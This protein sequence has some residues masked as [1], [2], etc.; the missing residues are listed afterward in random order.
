M[1]GHNYKLQQ[2]S[3][4]KISSNIF[5]RIKQLRRPKDVSQIANANGVSKILIFKA[6]QTGD[7]SEKVYE[8]LIVFYA[9]RALEESKNLKSLTPQTTFPLLTTT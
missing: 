7:C 4:M 2:T 9:K 5:E 8:M 3:T 1:V 6:L